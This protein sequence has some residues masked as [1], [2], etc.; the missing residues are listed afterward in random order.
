[1]AVN[2]GD[3]V[4]TSLRTILYLKL[5]RAI[6][7]GYAAL[8]NSARNE[9]FGSCVETSLRV[10]GV[11]GRHFLELQPR[12]LSWVSFGTLICDMF[13]ENPAV[14]PTSGAR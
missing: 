8:F 10:S 9:P 4:S 2:E 12:Q 7:K 14:G 11:W 13:H 5:V 6:V 3:D 1:V